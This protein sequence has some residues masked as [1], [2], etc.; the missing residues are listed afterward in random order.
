MSDAYLRL[1][2]SGLTCSIAVL[3]SQPVVAQKPAYQLFD[4]AGVV[5]QYEQMI[6]QLDSADLVL[7]GEIHNDALVHWLTLQVAKDLYAR[8]SNLVIGAEMLEADDQLILDEYLTGTIELRH[9]EQEA[10]LWDNY[11]TD[12][13]PLVN[14]AQQQQIPVVA[15]NVPRR[16]A[17]LVAREGLSRLDSLPGQAKE[18][19]APLPIEVD[20]TLPGYQAMLNMMGGGSSHGS[21]N[22]QN[23]AHAQAIKDATM[24]HFIMLNLPKETTFL[25]VNGS[26]HSN[27]FEGIYWYVQQAGPDVRIKTIACVPQESWAELEDQ[28]RGL[29]DFIIAVPADMTKTY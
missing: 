24:A 2:L 22:A 9:F 5:V 26:Y 23:M 16:Y 11:A 1:V 3:F 18:Y 13:A 25:H 14:F 7:F 15:T 12:Y 4:S 20:L 17:S 6:Q 29:A 10:K 19:L 21:M 27:N 8:D 28:Y